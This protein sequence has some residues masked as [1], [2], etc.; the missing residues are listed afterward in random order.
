MNDDKKSQRELSKFIDAWI[1]KWNIRY[2]KININ[3][4][5]DL[6]YLE[7]TKGFTKKELSKE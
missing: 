7:I 6:Q 3:I 4:R 5:E 1:E 2:T